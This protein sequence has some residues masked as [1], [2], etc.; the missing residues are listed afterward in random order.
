MLRK[1]RH[2]WSDTRSACA[3]G[4]NRKSSTDKT[5]PASRRSVNAMN[6]LYCRHSNPEDEPRCQRCGRRL[7]VAPARPEPD[8]YVSYQA[9]QATALAVAMAPDYELAPPPV[10]APPQRAQVPRQSRLFS[11]NE[12]K[13]LQF[14]GISKPQE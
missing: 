7:Q 11:D 6:C 5:L 2:T 1:R 10:A 3:E 14:P 12:S 9:P 13:I 4:T 8:H